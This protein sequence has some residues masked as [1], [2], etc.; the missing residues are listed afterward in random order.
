M[1]KYFLFCVT[2]FMMQY[3][4][5]QEILVRPYLQPGNASQLNEEQ[6]VLIWQTDSIPG[7]FVVSYRM[8]GEPENSAKTATAKVSNVKLH[9]LNKTT[10]LYRS[11]LTDL[12][13][14][15]SYQYD[16]TL[17]GKSIANASFDTRTKKP[18]TRFA[19]LGDFGAGS[20]QQSLIAKQIAK[21]LPQFVLTTGDNVYPDGLERDYRNNLFPYYLDPD[22]I[23]G[24]V[25]SLMNTIPFYMVLGNHDVRS[26]NLDSLPDGLAYFYY[27]DL[28]LNA[29]ITTRTISADGRSGVTK[30]FKKNTKPRFPRIANF[31]FDYG[32]VHF[33]CL[34]ANYYVN[35]LDPQLTQWLKDDIGT[36]KAD[37]KI[38]TFHQP[39][40]NSSRAHYNEQIMR[41][42]SPLMEQLGVDLV[43]AGHVHNYQRTVPLKF[44][45]ERNKS[46][47]EYVVSPEGK[48]NGKFQLDME[49]DGDRNTSPKG[50][51]YI[52]T[53]AGG[54]QLYNW[55]ETGKPELWKHEPAENWAPFTTK[56]IADIF[57][58]T[59]IETNGKL[60]TLQ[61]IDMNGNVLDS[62]KIT[63]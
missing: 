1:R 35:P 37:W 5:A 48:V 40:F 38:V 39:G 33:S 54:G 46:G 26:D 49:F 55:G 47:D 53:G 42:L 45:P 2:I 43:L 44:D 22:S 18:H 16:I 50:I 51:V 4:K 30:A 17:N 56:F 20:P 59:F 8:K 62:I 60:L 15:T 32:N 34:D 6:K 7:T 25:S 24:K 11:S 58:F 52:I 9:L 10:F 63:K 31:S 41:L 23:G 3:L 61:Q 28:P 36:S 12:M 27:S 29:P 57:S 21:N 14:D 19:V 13:F